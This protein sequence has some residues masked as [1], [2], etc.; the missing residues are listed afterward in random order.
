MAETNPKRIPGRWREGFALDDHIVSSVYVGDN[1][2]GHP[3]FVTT[4]TELGELLFRLK[5][6]SD[7]SCVREIVDAAAEFMRSWRPDLDL[8]VPVPAT[9]T[10]LVQPVVLLSEALAE[11]LGTPFDPDCVRRV[12]EISELKNVFGFDERFRLLEGAFEVD[13]ER[14]E[15]RRI[16]LMDDLFRSGATM[17][18][19]TEA[20]FSQGGGEVFALAITRTKGR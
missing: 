19:I 13:R 16:L 5:Y 18:V 12:R 10:R 7:Q 20:L 11:R 15:G 6:R 3:E 9:R 2:F 14:V 1:E 8:V 4:R 17:N